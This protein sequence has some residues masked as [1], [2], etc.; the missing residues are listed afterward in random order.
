MGQTG[1]VGSSKFVRTVTEELAGPQRLPAFLQNV[2]KLKRQRVVWGIKTLLHLLCQPLVECWLVAQRNWK[3][4][5]DRIEPL[6]PAA[7]APA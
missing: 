1:A 3:E 4:L 5:T 7:R 6:L 2:L